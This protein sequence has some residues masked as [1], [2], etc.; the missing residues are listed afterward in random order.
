MTGTKRGAE[1]TDECSG[2]HIEASTRDGRPNSIQSAMSSV[3]AA[4]KAVADRQR[5]GIGQVEDKTGTQIP[6][7]P[8]WWALTFDSLVADGLY[9]GLK[10]VG[11]RLTG[12][13]AWATWKA[14]TAMRAGW[15]GILVEKKLIELNK[16]LH[17]QVVAGMLKGVTAKGVGAVRGSLM[18]EDEPAPSALRDAFFR[19]QIDSLTAVYANAVTTLNNAE[20]DYVALE[21]EAPG[22]AFAAL[23]AYREHLMCAPHVGETAANHALGMWS[24]FLA[25]MELGTHEPES[26]EHATP[27]VAIEKNIYGSTDARHRLRDTA[28]GVL[29]VGVVWSYDHRRE[30]P[31]AEI[32][33]AR[34]AG[35]QPELKKMLLTAPLGEFPMPII[36]HGKV[37]QDSYAPGTGRH[38]TSQLR[39]A[40]NEGGAISVGAER[41]SL[42]AE[43]LS[44][45]GGGDSFE[46]ARALFARVDQISLK[47]VE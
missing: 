12:G 37:T 15:A 30:A 18:L 39:I 16:S 5:H 40:R 32:R 7:P 42:G 43:L 34:V 23:E 26:W 24:A 47:K 13:V 31:I 11:D 29:E 28:R 21:A 25:R 9:R 45:V 2:V 3:G 6:K 17:D 8:P 33:H 41:G 46:G 38:T 35:L 27:G 22:L 14:L 10:M 19:A 20:G 44:D 36:V 1:V 4:L